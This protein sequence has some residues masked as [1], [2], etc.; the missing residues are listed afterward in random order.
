MQST[1][2][3]IFW[4]VSSRKNRVRTAKA[5]GVRRA[6]TVLCELASVSTKA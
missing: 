4:I 2:M 6:W 1:M 3:N 5:E